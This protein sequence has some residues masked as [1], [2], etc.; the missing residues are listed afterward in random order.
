MRTPL[1]PS[2]PAQPAQRG[3]KAVRRS[4]PGANLA[5]RSLDRNRRAIRQ[6][7]ELVGSPGA[8]LLLSVL[9]SSSMQFWACKK[10]TRRMVV[11]L[12]IDVASNVAGLEATVAISKGGADGLG[13]GIAVS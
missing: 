4:L 8:L 3:V 5:E 2:L 9:A 7:R 10:A 13:M 12:S 11:K 6:T 1:R